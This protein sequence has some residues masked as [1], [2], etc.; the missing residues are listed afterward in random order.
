MA[1]VDCPPYKRYYVSNGDST[2]GDVEM[3]FYNVWTSTSKI[4]WFTYEASLFARVW[5]LNNPSSFV[6]A[7]VEM[8]EAFEFIEMAFE[9][10]EM[11]FALLD[12][13]LWHNMASGAIG[14]V[15][16][17]D[18]DQRAIFVVDGVDVQTFTF[19][20]THMFNSLGYIC[21]GDSDLEVVE[22]HVLPTKRCYWGNIWDYGHFISVM[23]AF[24]VCTG[25]KSEQQSKLAARK[26]LGFLAKFKDFKIQNIV[27]SCDVKFPIRLEGLAYSHGAFSSAFRNE[28]LMN[29]GFW[30]AFEEVV[31]GAVF[32]LLIF[33]FLGHLLRLIWELYTIILISGYC[34]TMIKSGKPSSAMYC[35]MLVQYEAEI[36]PGLIYRMKQPKIVLLI[37]VS[38]KIVLTGAKVRDETYTAFENIY[39][40]LT[41]FRKTQQWHYVLGP[42]FYQAITLNTVFVCASL[43]SFYCLYPEGK[44]DYGRDGDK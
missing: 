37:F 3:R 29:L 39:P 15:F 8:C 38:G 30:T 35:I 14:F 32:S 13:T 4:R 34:Y 12:E 44:F 9:F 11:A 31:I 40:V 6:V 23:R 1:D 36:F 21:N 16:I 22:L 10:I 19:H 42:L 20:S 25:V 27:A 28:A 18:S 5:P 24:Q 17:D 43:I 2:S 7:T 26:K 41:E 33:S